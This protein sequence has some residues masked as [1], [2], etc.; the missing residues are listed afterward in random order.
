[1]NN[2]RKSILKMTAVSSSGGISTLLSGESGRAG[3]RRRQRACED[4]P[5]IVLQLNIFISDLQ[6]A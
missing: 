1:V 4:T 5:L 2:V 6:I 3:A